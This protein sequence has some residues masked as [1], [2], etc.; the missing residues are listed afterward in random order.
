MK[1]IL[2]DH[3]SIK[4][5]INKEA[6]IQ[7]E[8]TENSQYVVDLN[9]F[10]DFPEILIDFVFNKKNIN[11]HVIA[12]YSIKDQEKITTKIRAVHNVSN[13]SCLIDI[14]GALYDSSFSNHF[15]EIFIGSNA[16]RT[17]SYLSDHTLLLSENSKTISSPNLRIYNNDVKASHGASIGSVNNEKLYYLQSRGFDKKDAIDILVSGFFESTF[18]DITDQNMANVFR[19][20]LLTSQD[21]SL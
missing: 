6:P 1:C 15:G 8:V 16:F 2:I 4:N 14:K 3:N 5:L 20:K 7:I 9:S 18:N 17:E 21:K 11:A 12:I 19:Q 10:V 13:T